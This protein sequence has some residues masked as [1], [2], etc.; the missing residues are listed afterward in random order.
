MNTWNACFPF[1]GFMIFH[2]PFLGFYV[3]H[4]FHLF[5]FFLFFIVLLVVKDSMAVDVM[6]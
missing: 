5:L 6:N 4:L 3:F 2:F 1:I